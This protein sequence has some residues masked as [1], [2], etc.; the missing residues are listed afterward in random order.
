MGDL[1]VV[2]LDVLQRD[3]DAL[4]DTDVRED[5]SAAGTDTR[6]RS[7]LRRLGRVVQ[8]GVSGILGVM[9]ASQAALRLAH[10][11]SKGRLHKNDDQKFKP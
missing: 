7:T 9:T 5:L 10:D 4:V 2:L 3:D 11:T 6:H 8:H 1:H